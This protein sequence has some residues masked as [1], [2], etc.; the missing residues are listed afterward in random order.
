[1]GGGEK[2]E[3]ARTPCK[4]PSLQLYHPYYLAIQ[5]L[6]TDGLC[7]CYFGVCVVLDE[8]RTCPDLRS[9]FA[10]CCG[11][12]RKEESCMWTWP[13]YVAKVQIFGLTRISVMF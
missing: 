2:K 13:L 12:S 10:I 1:M 11:L 7:F 3:R 6:G 8:A 4:K 9:P 5:S